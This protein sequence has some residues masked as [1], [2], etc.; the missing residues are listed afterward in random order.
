MGNVERIGGIFNGAA[1]FHGD[2]STWQG[3]WTS[4]FRMFS[5]AIRFN[6]PIGEWDMSRVTSLNQMFAW[7]EAFN[8]PLSEWDVSSASSL[9]GTFSVS[10]CL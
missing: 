1:A 8:Q 7:T 10:K 3:R 9:G 5:H 2:I 6:Q 4:T